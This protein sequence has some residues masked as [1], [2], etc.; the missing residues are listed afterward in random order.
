M[1]SHSSGAQKRMHQRHCKVKLHRAA[2]CWRAS[3]AESIGDESA[4]GKPRQCRFMGNA[5]TRVDGDIDQG[6]MEER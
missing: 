1:K 2:K 3:Q 5:R 4:K 6:E